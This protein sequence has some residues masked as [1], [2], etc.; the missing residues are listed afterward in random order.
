MGSWVGIQGKVSRKRLSRFGGMCVRWCESVGRLGGCVRARTRQGG[1]IGTGIHD[2]HNCKFNIITITGRP[3]SRCR[4]R[5]ARR[6]RP[7]VRGALCFLVSVLVRGG[8][9]QAQG[10]WLWRCGE[11]GHTSS[12]RSRGGGSRRRCR[13]SG[14][15]LCRSPLA[16]SHSALEL[17]HLAFGG[18]G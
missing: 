16:R 11:G 6:A 13:T 12:T 9:T 5:R 18:E 17:R 3:A 10:S 2:K 8:G 1:A 14:W 15:N 7:A 4:A